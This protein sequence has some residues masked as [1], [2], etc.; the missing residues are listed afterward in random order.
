MTK[1]PPGFDKHQPTEAQLQ[2]IVHFERI[3]ILIWAL[4]SFPHWSFV[5]NTFLLS[6]HCSISAETHTGYDNLKDNKTISNACD[7]NDDKVRL[8]SFIKNFYFTEHESLAVRV[9]AE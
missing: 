4:S 2:L 7:E 8:H 1:I 6:D 3:I 9:I 5:L